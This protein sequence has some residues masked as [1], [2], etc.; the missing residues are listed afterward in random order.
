MKS[1]RRWLFTTHFLLG[2]T[3]IIVMGGLFFFRRIEERR[4]IQDRFIAAN[5]QVVELARANVEIE[6]LQAR[7][8]L[9]SLSQNPV[10]TPTRSPQGSAFLKKQLPSHPF[11]LN[12]G[13]VDEQ[14]RLFASALPFQP[15]TDLKDRTY[16]K[17]ALQ[18]RSYVSDAIMG[19]VTKQPTLILSIPLPYRDAS[20]NLHRGVIY[21]A[22]NFQKLQQQ[23]QKGLPNNKGELVMVDRQGTVILHPEWKYVEEFRN[24]KDIPPVRLALDKKTGFVTT[25]NSPLVPGERMGAYSYV[26]S[27]GWGIFTSV[28]SLNVMLPL[29][30]RLY[31]IFWISLIALLIALIFARRMSENLATPIRQL[32]QSA[33]ALS[34]GNF[35]QRIPVDRQDELGQ[36]ALSFNQ[37]AQELE[38]RFAEINIL[39]TDLEHRVE[40]RTRDL[41]A[42][43]AELRFSNQQLANTVEELQRLDRMRGEFLNII[44]HDLRIPLTSIV[45]Y[46][47]FLEEGA[48]PEAQADYV[49][50]ILSSSDRMTKLLDDL[51]DFA[52]M[53]AGKFRL[54][55]MSIDYSEVLQ[56]AIE[57]MRPLAEKK[58][59]ELSEDLTPMTVNAD[60]DRVVQMMNNL[61]S[62]AIKFTNPGGKV[63]IKSYP[64]DGF[65]VTEVSDTGKGIPP[66]SLPHMFEK[67]YRVDVTQ[68]GSGLGLAITKSLVEAHGGKI[69]LESTL[70]VG[71]TFRFTL[72]FDQE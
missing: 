40:E 12:F 72:P 64:E 3:I 60:P 10:L 42:Q 61:L 63:K 24:I 58:H 39:K 9:K 47:E 14:G 22:F 19:R 1:I 23:F 68:P 2:I 70:G 31:D 20:G 50:N 29:T 56:A 48:P 30:E 55:R 15:G 28:P 8:T 13:A 16:V 35:H 67:F 54:A 49:H 32:S 45:G 41:E 43:Q 69:T 7:A 66:E 46:A 25:F 37:M 33:I 36:L 18:G 62:N 65:A 71:T 26:P 27:A 21:Q 4:A 53:E 44:S 59:L 17:E 57:G 34:K 5:L 38:S 6:F 51:L 11:V 52:R